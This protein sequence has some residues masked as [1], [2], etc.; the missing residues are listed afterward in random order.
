MENPSKVETTKL[1][2]Y[3]CHHAR[4]VIYA[5]NCRFQYNQEQDAAAGSTHMMCSGGGRLVDLE[6]II[7]GD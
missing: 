6:P 7:S 5:L 1:I 3:Y 4:D 2:S